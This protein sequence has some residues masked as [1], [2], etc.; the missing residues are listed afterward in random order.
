[1]D[2]AHGNGALAKVIFENEYLPD[3][4]LKIRLCEICSR[5]KADFV[6]TSTGFGFV[7]HPDGSMAPIGATD[8]D[9]RL[10][11]AHTDPAIGLKA[12][13]GVRTIEDALRVGDLGATRIGTRS[14][15]PIVEGQRV[16]QE[17]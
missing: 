16:A 1:M 9:L 14:T 6:K 4:D 17:S 7:K 15:P 12:S 5:I 2:T 11:R 3:D 10:M 8:H 13:G